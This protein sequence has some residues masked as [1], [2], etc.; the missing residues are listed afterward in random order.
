VKLLLNKGLWRI[1]YL[2]IAD[3]VDYPDPVKLYPNYIRYTGADNP[4]LVGS[5]LDDD[6]RYVVSFPGDV[7]EMG[8]LLPAEKNSYE[9]FLL[10]K[11]Y[12]LEWIREDWLKGKDIGRLRKIAMDDKKA[13][14]ELSLEYKLN[15]SGMEEVFW[16]SKLILP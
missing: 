4:G 3:I 5:L 2:A 14:E 16:D 1:D 7:Y 6:E 11:G 13:W 9:L 8:F 12:Y 15:E 10:A